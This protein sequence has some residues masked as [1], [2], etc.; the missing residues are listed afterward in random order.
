MERALLKAYTSEDL[1]EK[2]KNKIISYIDEVDKYKDVSYAYI[3]IS[4]SEISRSIYLR[5]EKFFIPWKAENQL[6]IHAKLR[7]VEDKSPYTAHLFTLQYLD[8]TIEE[9]MEL[10]FTYVSASYDIQDEAE[11]EQSISISMGIN[12][13]FKYI[14]L[15]EKYPGVTKNIYTFYKFLRNRLLTLSP[16]NPELSLV[17]QTNMENMIVDRDAMT[18]DGA[19]MVVF[20][21]NTTLTEFY[22]GYKFIHI[23]YKTPSIYNDAGFEYVDD[24]LLLGIDQP[25]ENEESILNSVFRWYFSLKEVKIKGESFRC[26]IKE[27]PYFQQII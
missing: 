22:E 5:F 2:F 4:K 18:G 9:A 1:Y 17:L 26:Y 24:S 21:L 3:L 13:T 15:E 19:Y 11:F 12:R 23:F 14:D 27:I 20:T 25:H 8:T 6:I 16:T 7:Y 10:L